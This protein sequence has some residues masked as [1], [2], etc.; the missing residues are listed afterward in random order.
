M[1]KRRFGLLIALIIVSFGVAITALWLTLTEGAIGFA[2][3]NLIR[4]FLSLSGL[5]ILT[6]FNLIIRWVRWHFLLRRFELKLTTK[7]SFKLW[8]LTVPAIATPF[9]LGELVRAA[10]L[11]KRYP[12]SLWSITGIWLVER[13]ADFLIISVFFLVVHEQWLIISALVGLGILLLLISSSF[14]RAKVVRTLTKPAA[15]GAVFLGTACAW[16]FPVIGLWIVMG[17]LGAHIPAADV[18]EVFSLGTLF[19]GI[20]GIPLGVGVTGSIMIFLLQAKGIVPE[21]A[22]IAIAIFRAGTVWFAVGI[23]LFAVIIWKDYIIQLYR[24]QRPRDR[25]DLIAQEYEENLPQHIRDRLLMRKVD[26]MYQELEHRGAQDGWL[27]LDIGCG[28][29]WYVSE[30][31]KRGFNMSAC[32]LSLQQIKHADDFT[33]AEKVDVDLCVADGASLPYK[34]CAFDFAFSVNVIHHITQFRARWRAFH[35][36]VRVIKPGGIFFLQEINTENPIFR[37]Y[38]G[39]IFPLLRDIDDGTEQWLMPTAL[40]VLE[41]ATW[42]DEIIYFNFLPDFAPPFLM[43]TLAGFERYLESSRF[44]RWSSHYIACLVKE[45]AEPMG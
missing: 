11:A 29:G 27:G 25:F 26:A 8:L 33:N 35:E 2:T 13:L 28:Q 9:Y 17:E 37:F 10:L 39:Y 19:G 34:D 5:V 20:T 18:T 3:E 38:M 45:Q 41:G 7:D 36:I 6:T 30:M 32:D 14:F 15:I 21:V 22:T 31:A 4:L 16:I 42:V 43:K 1:I 12:G 24:F 40:P 23:G 44:R